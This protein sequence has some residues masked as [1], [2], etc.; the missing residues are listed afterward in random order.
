MATGGTVLADPFAASV[1]MLELDCTGTPYQRDESLYDAT[2]FLIH[3]RAA[4]HTFTDD[5]QH[6]SW[7]SA[8][9]GICLASLSSISQLA[10]LPAV[11]FGTASVDCY[12]T[13]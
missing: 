10:A 7:T 12:L 4:P 11:C 2:N 13:L 9:N 3:A 1:R 5:S 8:M 6:P